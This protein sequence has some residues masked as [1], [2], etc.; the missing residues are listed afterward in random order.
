VIWEIR[1]PR[2]LTALLVGA[3]LGAA[4]ACLQGLFRNPL[5]D[6]GLIGVSSGGAIG[7]IT[8]IALGGLLPLGGGWLAGWQVPLL[9]MLGS[10]LTTLLVY[11]IAR[12]AGRTHVSTLLLA[13]VAVNALAGA[14][15]GAVLYVSDN[16]A[17]RRFTFWT[18]GGLHTAGWRQLAILGSCTIIPLLLLP[19][20][21]GALNAFLLGEAEAYHLGFATQRI[22]RL[23]ILLSAVMVGVGV[24][25]CGL[26]GFVGLVV[27]HMVR[28]LSGPDYR[29]LLP[30]SMLGGALLLLLADLLAR[31]INAPGEVPI[32]VVTSLLGA[33]FFLYLIHRRKKDMGG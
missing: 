5:A 20:Y 1:V 3:G 17:L 33:P 27:P 7:A 23:V 32:G 22:K 29:R 4:G 19:R 18:L 16:D 25:F 9:A 11:R 31:T 2:A 15:V 30:A 13:G 24:A 14:L 26:I 10:V 21:R 8:G 12:I 28:L 6:P